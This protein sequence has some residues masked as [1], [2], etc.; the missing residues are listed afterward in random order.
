MEMKATFRRRGCNVRL[1]A[2][3][4]GIEITVT[5][6]ERNE[7]ASE[8]F[9]RKHPDSFGFTD[10]ERAAINKIVNKY[11]DMIGDPDGPV[12]CNDE[13]HGK[14]S[15]HHSSTIFI[16]KSGKKKKKKPE[17]KKSKTKDKKKKEKK[18]KKYKGLV[19]HVKL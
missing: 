16:G 11:L 15:H 10:G 6:T 17:K 18:P 1:E 3:S 13:E 19:S 7:S 5:N 9:S 12:M 14:K 8:I 4:D 2:V